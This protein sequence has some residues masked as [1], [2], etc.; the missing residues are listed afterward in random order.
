MI[1][2]LRSQLPRTDSRLQRYI[3]VLKNKNSDYKVVGWNREGKEQTDEQNILYHKKAPIGG[4]MRNIFSLILWNVFLFKVL[5]KEKKEIK[6]IHAIDFDTAI[7]AY[8]FSFLFRKEF[9]LDVYDKYT[10]AR[11]M[12]LFVSKIIDK[13]ELFCCIRASKLILPDVCR[14][15]QLNLPNSVNPIIIENVP[16]VSNFENNNAKFHSQPLV[17]SYVGI[18]EKNHRG[19]ENLLEVISRHSDVK[20]HIAG[21]GELKSYVQKMSQNFKNI[22]YYGG[23]SPKRALEIMSESHIIVGMYYK[24]IK[25]HLY[26]SPNKYYEHLY[27]GKAL[28]TTDGTPPGNKVL[29]YNTGYVIGETMKDIE[30]FI[31]NIEEADLKTKSEN[32]LNLWNLKYHNYHQ[33]ISNLY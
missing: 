5:L 19:L 17:F 11:N 23:V 30:D 33:L 10:D 1:I 21:D 9:I 15:K 8:I 24:T 12:P 7:P 2:F 27:L 18:L 29:E 28:L 31:K 13:I 6:T 16:L 14:V 32:A 3:S 22:I 25:N 4:G 26:A 20:L